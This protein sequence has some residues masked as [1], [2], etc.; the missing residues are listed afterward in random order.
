[1]ESLDKVA[2]TV[3]LSTSSN[4]QFYSTINRKLG[5]SAVGDLPAGTQF[6]ESKMYR[7]GITLL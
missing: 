3:K 7:F 6:S 5:L 1:L 4:L 2:K